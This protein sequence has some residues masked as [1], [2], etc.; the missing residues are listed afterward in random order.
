M[1]L[2]PSGNVYASLFDRG[3]IEKFSPTGIN[4]G[5]IASGLR[6]PAFLQYVNPVPEPSSLALTVVALLG[7]AGY[8][9]R[10]LREGVR[11]A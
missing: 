6:G 10:R 7:A 1:T 2:D 8:H 4:L 3:T 11:A 5:P 9:L